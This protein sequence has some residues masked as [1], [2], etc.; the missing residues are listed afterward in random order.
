MKKS[1]DSAAQALGETR[2]RE[3]R[4]EE[5]RKRERDR[6]KKERLEEEGLEKERLQRERRQIQIVLRPLVGR[7][8]SWNVTIDGTTTEDDIREMAEGLSHMG[9]LAL[10]EEET[11][12]ES[13]SYVF[14]G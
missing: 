8:R 7:D 3:L 10:P 4:E 13:G 9:E 11:C 1:A 5:E 2:M 6:L 12:R 14:T